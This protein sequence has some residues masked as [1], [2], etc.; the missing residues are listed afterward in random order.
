MRRFGAAVA[1]AAPGAPEL[2]FVNRVNG[3]WPE[4]GD[5][6]DEIAEWYRSLRLRFWV[7]IV[8]VEGADELEG[9]LER[10][11]A[12]AVGRHSA[13]WAEC[14]GGHG[15]P[16]A[17]GPVSV[18]EVQ[19]P[20]VHGVVTTLL[21]GHEVPRE[22]RGRL[23]LHSHWPAIAGWRFYRAVVDG[24]AAGAGVLRLGEGVGLLAN[25][26]TVPRFRRRGVQTVLIQRRLA[27]A[28]SSGCDLLTSQA[29]D[30]SPS[31][32]NLERAGLHPAYTKTVW[33][34]GTTVEEL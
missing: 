23:D 8:P 6:V 3:L 15:A 24:E 9:A 11:G 30:G 5:R 10:A 31:L 2:D 16:A 4:D 28:V 7:E 33:R 25:A 14:V 13:V 20:E 34:L 27:D 1:F 22:A 29:A 18:S 21:D 17:S 26:S 12:E 32:R 19:P